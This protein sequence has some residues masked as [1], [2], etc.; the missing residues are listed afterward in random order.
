MKVNLGAG[1][2]IKSGWVNIDIGASKSPDYLQWDL[3][4]GL[5]S[6]IREADMFYSSHFWEHL[7][8]KE[9]NAL[10]RL[11]VERLKSGGVFRVSVPDFELIC[12]KYLEGD[13]GFFDLLHWN[14]FSEPNRRSFIDVVSY[15]VYQ[16][17]DGVQEH[18]T[19]WDSQ[20]LIKHLESYGLKDVKI[21]KY[22]PTID[23]GDAAR[24]R[25]S[26]YAEGIK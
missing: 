23:P 13:W 22:D 14:N 3:S 17:Q 19:I 21:V 18:K 25:Y 11:C 24:R 2:D 15:T 6:Y 8:E 16:I 9:A 4:K 5:P 10:G 26:L 1:Q 20:K 12:R 7:E